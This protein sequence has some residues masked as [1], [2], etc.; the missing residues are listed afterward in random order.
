MR[1]TTRVGE[2]CVDE[3]EKVKIES[4]VPDARV[5]AC[6]AALRE[7]VAT[8]HIGDGRLFVLPVERSIRIRNGEEGPQ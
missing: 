8:G 1:F 7:H 3:I 5:E 2:F 6:L 4:V